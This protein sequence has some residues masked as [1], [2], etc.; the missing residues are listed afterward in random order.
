MSS[1]INCGKPFGT[2]TGKRLV[3]KSLEAR[4]ET[5]DRTIKNVIEEEYGV[6]L[7]PAQKEKRFLCSSCSRTLASVAKST[8]SKIKAKKKLLDTASSTAYL[9]QKIHNV[10]LQRQER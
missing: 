3:R 5:L 2:T 8:E 7:T 6:T 4:L 9:K 1:C 10:S